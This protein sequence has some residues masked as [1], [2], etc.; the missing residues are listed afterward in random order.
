MCKIRNKNPRSFRCYDDCPY[1]LAR[2]YAIEADTAV[3]NYNY[4]LIM[5]NYAKDT[6]FPARDFTVCDEAH[7]ILDIVQNHYSPRF[8]GNVKEKLQSLSDFFGNHRVAYHNTDVGVVSDAIKSLWETENQDLIHERLINIEGALKNFLKSGEVLKERI[9][10][11][12]ENSRPPRD[13]RRALFLSDWVKDLHCKV[14]DYNYIIRATSTRNIVK[15]PTQDELVF[16]C[17]EERFLMNRYFHQFTGFTVLMSATFSDPREYMKNM[18]IAGAK[19]IK[20]DNLFSF[21]KSPIFYYPNK[22]MSYKHIE[23]NSPWL[24]EKVNELIEKHDGESG[25]IHT[26]SYDLTTKIRDNLTSANRKRVFVY[27]GTD[28]K[29]KALDTMK[30][31]K[32][33]IIMGPSL[34]TGLDLKDDFARFSIIAKIPYPSLADRFVKTKMAINPGWYKWVTIIEILQSIGR[35][36][37]HDED[38][39]ITYIL[40]G[41][42]SDLIH[43]NRSSFPVEFMQR[44]RVVNE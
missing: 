9:D 40:D 36:V 26:A 32:G 27:S 17:I 7:K 16:N 29:R 12:Y 13:W 24:F 42:L 44:I 5:Q 35:T 6:L 43:N 31:T 11:E 2:N 18:N 23:A 19:H 25:L 38:W 34:R 39:A 30:I 15:N 3:L 1:F 41:S 4:W 28:E 14:E 37:R 21:E 20:M 10:K 8:T 22:R 33:Q